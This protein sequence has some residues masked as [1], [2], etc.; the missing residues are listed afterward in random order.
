MILF[1]VTN[2]YQSLDEELIPKS[3][4]YPLVQ[5]SIFI[6]IKKWFCFGIRTEEYMYVFQKI[7]K[8]A[9]KQ[10]WGDGEG[11]S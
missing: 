8:E 1:G 6:I 4:K 5:N 10:E 7:K 9:R 11:W 2:K 3:I